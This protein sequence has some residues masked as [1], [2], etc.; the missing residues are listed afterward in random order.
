MC[1]MASKI[2]WAVNLQGVFV[3]VESSALDMFMFFYV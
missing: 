3:R 2:V 1:R